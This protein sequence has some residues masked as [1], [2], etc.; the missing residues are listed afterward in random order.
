[1]EHMMEENRI[2][3]AGSVHGEPVFSHRVREAEFYKFYLSVER[4]SGVE[5]VLPV[6]AERSR[7]PEQ[8]LPG[9]SIL[10]TGQIRTFAFRSTDGTERLLTNA[11]AKC[12]TALDFPAQ[13]NQVELTG[14]LLRPPTYRTTPRLREIT[15][16]VLAVP[17]GFQK[18][19]QIPV[20]A[21]GKNA[22]RAGELAAGDRIRLLGRL[23]SRDYQKRLPDGSLKEKSTYEVSCT[24]FTLL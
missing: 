4:T 5:D 3:L 13:K 14:Q 6:L 10:V 21:W 9:C 12:I 2:V 7:M 23:Q 24:C 20:I 8:L 11:F 15:D 22:R 16:L 17:R 19:D 1:M 18:V